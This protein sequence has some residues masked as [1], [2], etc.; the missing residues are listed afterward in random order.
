MVID[1]L[2]REECTKKEVLERLK[3]KGWIIL[4]NSERYPRMIRKLERMG[5]VRID[6]TGFGPINPYAWSTSIFLVNKI[7]NLS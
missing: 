6:F 7:S 5:F 3:S 1:G 4:D 2:Y